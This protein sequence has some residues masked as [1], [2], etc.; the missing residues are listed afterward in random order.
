M[1]TKEEILE[2]VENETTWNRDMCEAVD[3]RDYNRIIEYFDVDD[4]DVFGFC[5]N[6][7]GVHGPKEYTEENIKKDMLD[8]LEF[9]IEKALDQRGISASLMFEVMK[10]WLWVLED[11]EFDDVPYGF[12]GLPLYR[13]IENKY[14]NKKDGE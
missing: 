1:K 5:L 8:S 12:Y 2:A 13:A 10:M 14:A 4:F 3:S 9:A 7:G 11:D 6:E